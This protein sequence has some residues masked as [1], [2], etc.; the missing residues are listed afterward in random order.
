VAEGSEYWIDEAGKITGIGEI[1]SD[2]REAR[3]RGRIGC[4][5]FSDRRINR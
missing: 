1:I 5:A 2:E 4:H 3:A